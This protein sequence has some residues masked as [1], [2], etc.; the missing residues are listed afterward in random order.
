MP[1]VGTRK[2]FHMLLDNLKALKVGRDRLFYI[3]KANHLL[4][5]PKRSAMLPLIRIIDSES[6]KI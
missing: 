1:Q 2:L 6:I 4:I 5:S 3:L